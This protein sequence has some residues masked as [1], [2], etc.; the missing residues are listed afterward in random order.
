VIVT[1][2]G[3]MPGIVGEAGIV[4][5][6]ND[7]ASMGLAIRTVL[8]DAE[9]GARLGRLG[10]RRV[11][12]L[13]SVDAVVQRLLEHYRKILLRPEPTRILQLA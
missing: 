2:V 4:V 5:P 11:E 9:R 13:Y 3:E 1:R 8:S 6:T 12:E 10:R 7:P